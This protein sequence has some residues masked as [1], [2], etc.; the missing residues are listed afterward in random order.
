MS[1]ESSYAQTVLALAMTVKQPEDRAKSEAAV[2]VVGYL[3]PEALADVLEFVERFPEPEHGAPALTWLAERLLDTP[4]TEPRYRM[5][6]LFLFLAGVYAQAQGTGIRMPDTT[7]LAD[8]YLRVT[9]PSLLSSGYSGDAGRERL[10]A[11]LRTARATM[12]RCGHRV[13][14]PVADRPVSR[15][16]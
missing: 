3:F 7:R 15:A 5:L 10:L 6:A 4:M 9:L 2:A 1:W 11:E 13:T 16:A 14:A 8:P 12:L